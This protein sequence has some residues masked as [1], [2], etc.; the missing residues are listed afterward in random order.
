VD[1]GPG[2]VGLRG[3]RLHVPSFLRVAVVLVAGLSLV[4]GAPPLATGASVG[5]DTAATSPAASPCSGPSL[6]TDFLGSLVVDGG[7]APLPSVVGRTISLEYYV[8]ENYTPSGGPSTVNCLSYRT[9]NVTDGVGGFSLP[10]PVPTS[11][12]TRSSCTDYQGPLAPLSVTILN[13]TPAGYFVTTSVNG[14]SVTASYVFALSDVALD[15]SGRVTLS[16]D[17]PTTVRATAEA[18][19]GAA[20]PANLSYAW[21]LTGA[22]WNVTRGTG[23]ANLT[24]EAAPDAGPG[25]LEL[26]VNGTYNGTTEAAAPAILL[27]DAVAT[28][29]E[30]GNVQ[31]TSLDVGLPALFDV[32]G[33]GAIGYPYD[34][35]IFPGAGTTSVTAPCVENGTDGGTEYVD[36][37]ASV[38]YN[39]TG[40]V[41]PS[42][43]LTNG[44]SSAASEFPS[45][46]IAPSP[47]VGVSP[48]PVVAYTGSETPVTVSVAGGTGTGP[49]GAACLSTGNGREFCDPG[50]G[51]S[52]PFLVAWGSP[53]SYD[54]SAS[55]S[56]H[57]GANVTVPVP[58]EIYAKLNASWV[59]SG[60]LNPGSLGESYNLSAAVVGGA[61]PLDYWWNA[62][63]ATLMFGTIDGD[64]GLFFSYAPET[65]GWANVTLAVLDRLGTR[66]VVPFPAL[67]VPGSPTNVDLVGGGAGEVLAGV[68]YELQWYAVDALGVVTP[69]FQAAEELAIDPLTGE[70]GAPVWV[71]STAGPLTSVSPGVFSIP[72]GAWGM[73]HLILNVTIGGDGSFAVHLLGLPPELLGPA[74]APILSVG[75]NVDRL[76]LWDPQHVNQGTRSGSTLYRV[77]DLFDDNV[78]GGFLRIVEEFGSVTSAQSSAILDGA[79]GSFAWVNYSALSGSTGSVVVT[80]DEQN[81]SI[82]SITVPGAAAPLSSDALAGIGILAAVALA[83]G[84]AIALRRRRGDHPSGAIA[85]ATEA[86][87]ERLSQ[88]RSHVL[89]RA[90]PSV[91]RTLEELSQ[92][93]PGRPP[94]PE[95]ITEWV[96]SLVSDGSLRSELGVDGHSRFFL[97]APPP[98]APR[99]ELDD[100]ALDEALRRRRE[101]EDDGP[102][103]APPPSRP[104]P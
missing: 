4:A 88:G 2:T 67:I 44:Y 97:T 46:T 66:E 42:A 90:D 33:S 81:R 54:A 94:S 45:L 93:F 40:D 16:T 71:N 77:T 102:T 36:C 58:V 72:A 5:R 61:L 35:E 48:S 100:R 25:D 37:E 32:R 59:S 68:P 95:E 22:E 43:I 91:G 1:S 83:S 39:S 49:L 53:G 38:T 86:E 56:D 30:P 57:A 89:E 62:S 78:S 10:A 52:Y 3:V 70:T 99:V 28:S 101:L 24:I 34:A 69:Q 79:D 85:P 12:C 96:A 80:Y 87:L 23:S 65:I 8:R 63:G 55:V 104:D 103:D 84:I 92:G 51:P 29:A 13:A 64:G 9:T 41:Q 17:A 15:P 7:P 50:P 31:P 19:N 98:P 20:S 11:G 21:R 73:G 75:T 60:G 6:P 14:P 74:V 76:K 18:G 47:A 26:W 27:L 82:L